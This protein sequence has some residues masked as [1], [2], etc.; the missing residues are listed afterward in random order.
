[1]MDFNNQLKT[2]L[3]KYKKIEK[4]YR[5]LDTKCKEDTLLGP[6]EG[7]VLTIYVKHPRVRDLV[8]LDEG[9]II[10]FKSEKANVFLANIKAVIYTDNDL[11]P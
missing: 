11:T 1:M 7:D 5:K 3:E 6:L 8:Y 2:I 10:D 4:H 9:K